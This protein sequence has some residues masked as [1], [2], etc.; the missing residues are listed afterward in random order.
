MGHQYM[1]AGPGFKPG[2]SHM[3]GKGGEKECRAC[4]IVV[5]VPVLLFFL[6]QGIKQAAADDVFNANQ[7]RACI[8]L[9]ED[10]ALA[11][12]LVHMGAVV[13]RLHLDTTPS[14]AT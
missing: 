6:W 1:D 4:L 9:V 11:K 5:A 14:K 7:P 13:M 12:L 10:Y 8:I 3:G 2:N